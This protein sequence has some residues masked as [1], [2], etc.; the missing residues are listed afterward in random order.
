MALNLAR[1]KAAPQ[2][3]PGT[4]I[5]PPIWV[6]GRQRPKFD[7]VAF[8]RV[9]HAIAKRDLPPAMN[10]A[11]ARAKGWGK[12]ISQGVAPPTGRARFLP[13]RRTMGGMI[14]SLGHLLQA[15]HDLIAPPSAAPIAHP[16]LL[17]PT[18]NAPAQPQGTQADPTLHAVRRAIHAT[19][20]SFAPQSR[21]AQPT[22]LPGIQKPAGRHA[23]VVH[24]P[25]HKPNIAVARGLLA[26]LMLLAWPAAAIHALLYHLDGLDL[27]NWS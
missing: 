10:R 17:R 5:R 25:H 3:M 19:G 9:S 4:P 8:V 2:D 23:A 22:A 21:P 11:A 27:R 20:P 26:V 16:G 6:Q 1:R 7:T 13:S 18:V 15:S 24:P 14:H 12:S